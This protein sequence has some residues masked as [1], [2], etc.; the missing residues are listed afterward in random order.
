MSTFFED[1]SRDDAGQDDP[2][3]VEWAAELAVRIRDGE[4]VDWEEL[5]GRHP[6]RA[7][8]LRR[9]LPAF[10]LMARLGDPLHREAAGRD[11]IPDPMAELGCLGDYRLLR[12]VGRGGMGVVYEGHQIS[13]KRRVALKVLPVR[14]GDGRAPASAVPD[15]GPGRRRAAPCEHRPGL[16]RRY[17][18]RRALLCDAVHRGPQ[19]RRGHPRA[20]AARRPGGGRADG[21]VR[22]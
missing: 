7:E 22:R 9:M 19:P 8:T 2:L 4:T 5:A 20:A 10:A 12:E 11:P 16:R 17:R 6:E 15:R 3:L 21:G 1:E 14:L 13:L 18:T